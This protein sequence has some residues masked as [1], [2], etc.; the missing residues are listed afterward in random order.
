MY[1]QTPINSKTIISASLEIMAKWL[2]IL[3]GVVLVLVLL[4]VCTSVSFRAVGLMPIQGDFELLQ[5]GLAVVVGSFLPWC[6]SQGNNMFIDFVTTRL[7]RR[8][9]NKLDA[10]SGLLVSIMLALI[11]W[12]TG[13]GAF[14]SYVSGEVTMIRGFPI[15][16][17]YLL[18]VP[19]LCL[20]SLLALDISIR[21]WRDTRSV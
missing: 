3:G 5:V 8:N 12:R 6:H 20:T 21:R 14:A 18:M 13:A 9:Q 15:W 11:A 7:S 17:S 10:I 4:M 19:G 1:S 16:V 2:A